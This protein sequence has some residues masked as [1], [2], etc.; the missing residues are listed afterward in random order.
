MAKREGNQHLYFAGVPV[1]PD[2]KLLLGHF[3]ELEP[4]TQ[5]KHEDVEPVLGLK[6]KEHRYRTVVQRWMRELW[7]DYNI[8]MVGMIGG[9]RVLT[10]EERLDQSEHQR[11]KGT[12][13]LLQSVREVTTT[14]TGELSKAEFA[15]YHHLLVS[16]AR[17]LSL[18]KDVQREYGLALRRSP[19]ALPQKPEKFRS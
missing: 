15:R 12:R 18:V 8:R 4:G 2:V 6:R 10:P 17:A 11:V 5:I 7:D 13:R 19:E 16:N 1:A 3:Q 14:P 9:F